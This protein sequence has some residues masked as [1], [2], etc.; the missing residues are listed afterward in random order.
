MPS[1]FWHCRFGKK[2]YPAPIFLQNNTLLETV[3]HSGV[4]QH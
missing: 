2:I 4:W 1:V 3:L